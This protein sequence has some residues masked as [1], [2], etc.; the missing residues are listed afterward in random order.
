M[1]IKFGYGANQ[2]MRGKATRII[3]QGGA[4]SNF[5]KHAEGSTYSGM[6]IEPDP[7]V[8][9]QKQQ[10]TVNNLKREKK[11]GWQGHYNSCF[12]DGKK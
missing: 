9:Q 6:V 7:V 8:R 4:G 1:E 10:Q 11:E 12:S 2:S 3:T 5:S